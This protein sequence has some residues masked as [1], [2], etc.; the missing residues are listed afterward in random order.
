MAAIMLERLNYKVLTA[1]TPKEA[2]Q[3]AKE[4]AGEIH[5]L[6]TDV[7]MPEMNG[8]ELSAQLLA[9]SPQLKVMYISGYTANVIAHHGILDEGIHFLQKPFSRREL[10]TKIRE[11]LE[12][13]RP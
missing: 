12:Q 4:H 7:I 10:A 5:L 2:L 6:I 1:N 13:D 8:K 11:V 3:Q 9:I